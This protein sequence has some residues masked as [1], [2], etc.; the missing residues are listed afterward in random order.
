MSIRN[1]SMQGKNLAS[2]SDTGEELGNSR[3]ILFQELVNL[4]NLTDS[5]Q[6]KVV[7]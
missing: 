5:K 2:P 3:E 4:Q 7:F 1:Y 6:K